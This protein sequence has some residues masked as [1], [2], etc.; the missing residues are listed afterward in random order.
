M[1][2]LHIQKVCFWCDGNGVC[3]QQRQCG[4][5]AISLYRSV[6]TECPNC[7]G[8]GVEDAVVECLE[9]DEI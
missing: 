5:S 6:F 1:K 2:E 4:S 3:W 8:T 9:Y 7:E